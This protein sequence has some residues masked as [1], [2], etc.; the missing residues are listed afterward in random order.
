MPVRA[1][2]WALIALSAALLLPAAVG[3]SVPQSANRLWVYPARGHDEY[4]STQYRVRVEQ[5]RVRRQAFVYRMRSIWHHE[6]PEA[7]TQDLFPKEN[8]W[9]T[10][11]F[12]GKVL[13][14][15]EPLT[16][17]ADAV[18]VR[19]DPPGIS[20]SL[21]DGKVRVEITRPGQ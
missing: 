4:R 19:P 16:V 7:W 14:I 2:P 20:A 3:A 18:E 15:V 10:F 6:Y 1:R 11:S 9:V 17:K 13:V 12:S 5:G 8:H 21:V